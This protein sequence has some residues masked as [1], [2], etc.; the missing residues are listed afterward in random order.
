MRTEIM[1]KISRCNEFEKEYLDTKTYLR[2]A[3]LLRDEGK[4]H[5]VEKLVSMPAEL[6]TGI[7]SLD[8]IFDTCSLDDYYHGEPEPH[9]MERVIAICDAVEGLFGEGKM[10]EVGRTRK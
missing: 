1:E 4:V 9:D 2:R 10:E 5:S 3:K 7:R 6:N 8:K